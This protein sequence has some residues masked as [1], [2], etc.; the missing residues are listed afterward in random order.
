M[1]NPDFDRPGDDRPT[2]RVSFG[3]RAS[4]E[5]KNAYKQLRGEIVEKPSASRRME[6][7]RERGRERKREH[8]QKRI[9][10]LIEIMKP[11]GVVLFAFQ[12][13]V[14]VLCCSKIAL[15]RHLSTKGK[16]VMRVVER[17][18]CICS[19]MF[20]RARV[21][22]CLDA[23]FDRFPKYLD[24]LGTDPGPQAH[25][26]QSWSKMLGVWAKSTGTCRGTEAQG[27]SYVSLIH[28]EKKN[29][30]LTVVQ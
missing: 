3:R 30:Q 2:A 23:A 24:A 10:W 5:V 26:Q 14:T 29:K 18:P 25:S 22:C 6:R 28:I 9:Q 7:E 27:L 20:Y 13:C 16:A 17:N 1:S 4:S 12:P 15:L 19:Y 21:E 11:A 8:L